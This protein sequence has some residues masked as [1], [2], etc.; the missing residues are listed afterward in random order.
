[1]PNGFAKIT[2]PD[3]LKKLLGDREGNFVKI[4][5]EICGREYRRLQFGMYTGRI[6]YSGEK[7]K[8]HLL[9]VVKFLQR[10]ICKNIC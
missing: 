6:P 4:F 9:K 1:M 3:W 8:K 2:L 7:D 10:Q 5:R